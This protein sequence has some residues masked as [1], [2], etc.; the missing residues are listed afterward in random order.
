MTSL[1]QGFLG[2][3]SDGSVCPRE[4]LLLRSAWMD[5]AT[6]A[7]AFWG[8]APHKHLRLTLASCLC[9]RPLGQSPFP[10]MVA[11]LVPLA[12]PFCRVRWG[13]PTWPLDAHP[14]SFGSRTNYLPKQEPAIPLPRGVSSPTDSFPGRAVC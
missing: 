3:L 11:A 6:G 5:P 1:K 13:V 8:P 7:W 4:T 2:S 10:P 14:F 9:R 12:P